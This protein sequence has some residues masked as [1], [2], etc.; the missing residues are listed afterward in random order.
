MVIL[1]ADGCGG[2]RGGAGIVDL[3]VINVVPFPMPFP[4]LPLAGLCE[5][6]HRLPPSSLSPSSSSPPSPNLLSSPSPAKAMPEADEGNDNIWSLGP[7]SSSNKAAACCS[8]SSASPAP[9]PSP[10]PPPRFPGRSCMHD[11]GSKRLSPISQLLPL[12]F[13]WTWFSGWLLLRE[14]PLKGEG[15]PEERHPSSSSK[16]A[17]I[18]CSS[19][20]DM[21]VWD[22]WWVWCEWFIVP[23]LCG[24]CLGRMGGWNKE[25]YRAVAS[26]V[27]GCL[28]V[29]ASFLLLR[30]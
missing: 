11:G 7:L 12:L 14:G 4:P 6:P 27:F 3:D 26:V 1:R 22:E 15:A 24:A 13:W 20:R 30:L 29:G 23:A 5:S 21:A 16:P 17:K 28:R 9:S 18:S 2:G 10:P 25:G 8:A 19:V